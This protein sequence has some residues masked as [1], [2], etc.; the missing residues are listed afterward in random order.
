MVRYQE[1]SS[2]IQINRFMHR[3]DL[4]RPVEKKAASGASTLG[5]TKTN[6]IARVASPYLRCIPLEPCP[7]VAAFHR[8]ARTLLPRWSYAPSSRG[9]VIRPTPSGRLSGRSRARADERIA[10]LPVRTGSDP[11]SAISPADRR[12][13]IIAG[14]AKF[15]DHTSFRRPR[16]GYLE[17]PEGMPGLRISEM[18]PRH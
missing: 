14:F 2:L 1:V 4:E 15:L 13:Q 12:T 18:R 9:R 10:H 11:G 6:G 16:S 3:R 5:L 8:G 17:A 7:T